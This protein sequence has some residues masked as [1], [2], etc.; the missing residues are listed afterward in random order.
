[1][2]KR[3]VVKLDTAPVVFTV[4]GISSHENHYRLSWSI[5]EQ[6]G[7]TFAQGINL[8]TESG[9]EF[10]CF[11]HQDDEQRLLLLS[12]RCEN[13]FL[14]EKYKNL[15]FILK[16]EGELNE[17]ELSAWIRNLKKVMLVSAAFPIPVNKQTLYLLDKEILD[18][19]AS[20]RQL[21]M[22]NTSAQSIENFMQSR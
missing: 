5:N 15:D 19:Y 4:I 11:V 8:V 6:L 10:T 1:M 9:K 2:A 17:T 21:R 12:N 3:N 7:Y 18:K 20:R 16:F 22:T 13:G 14:I